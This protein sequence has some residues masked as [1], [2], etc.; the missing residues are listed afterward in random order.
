MSPSTRQQPLF[1]RPSSEHSEEYAA[2]EDDALMGKRA[3]ITRIRP[4]SLREILLLAWAVAATVAIIVLAILLDRGRSNVESPESSRP[5]K[6]NLIFMVS[7]GQIAFERA[8]LQ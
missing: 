3:S 6:R 7:V 1:A 2:A 8:A 4:G 5:G